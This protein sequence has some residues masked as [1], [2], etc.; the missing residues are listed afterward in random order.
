MAP[1][2][3]TVI[4]MPINTTTV[5]Q[6]MS[7]P[8]Y[9]TVGMIREN[10][11]ELFGNI[12]SGSSGNE[13]KKTSDSDTLAVTSA[14]KAGL[15][16]IQAGAAIAAVKA[17]SATGDK[18]EAK[19]AAI[20]AAIAKGADESSATAAAEKITNSLSGVS[21][22]GDNPQAKQAASTAARNAYAGGAQF[23]QVASMAAS[24]AGRAGADPTEA[25]NIGL[26]SAKLTNPKNSNGISTLGTA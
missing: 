6:T 11:E 18:S 15:T 26:Q 21:E 4:I 3:K 23:W 12:K 20:A 16:A 5:K 19:K 17:S 24:A 13:I 8:R 1:I 7:A 25:V 10:N 22:V 14:L 2:G 9:G